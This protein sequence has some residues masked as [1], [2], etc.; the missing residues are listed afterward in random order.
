MGVSRIAPMRGWGGAIR[1]AIA[2]YVAASSPFS[3]RAIS[4]RVFSTP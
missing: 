4:W 3:A 2:P 1:F